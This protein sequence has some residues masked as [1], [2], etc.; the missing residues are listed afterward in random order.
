MPEERIGFAGEDNNCYLIPSR[1]IQILDEN[2]EPSVQWLDGEPKPPV[3]K[4]VKLSFTDKIFNFI[5][6]ILRYILK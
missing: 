3:P 2:M 4:E 5:V 1:V 6:K